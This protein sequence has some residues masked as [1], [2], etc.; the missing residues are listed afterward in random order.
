MKI[1]L[2]LLLS[3]LCTTSAYSAEIVI[4]KISGTTA[5]F[6]NMS[7]PNMRGTFSGT[8]DGILNGR[9]NVNRF[10]NFSSAVHDPSTAGKVIEVTENVSCNTLTIPVD[11][12]IVF[13]AGKILTVANGKALTFLGSFSA[14]LYQVFEALGS[15]NGLKE[16]RPEWFGAARDGVTDDTLAIQK[17]AASLAGATGAIL[18]FSPGKYLIFSDTTGTLASFANMNGIAVL[19]YGTTLEV[20]KTKTITASEG[21][22]F[23]FDNCKNILVD[24]FTTDGPAPDV[25]SSTVKGYEFVRCV[26]GCRNI[27]MP[28]NR[29]VNWIAGLIVS[30]ALGD[31]D[32]MRSQN[33]HIGTLDI[34][35][36]FYGINGQYSGDY[37]VVD[38]LRTDTVHRSFFVYGASNIKANIY[39]KD[40][41]SIDVPISSAGGVVVENIDISYHSGVDST[42]CGNTPK[43]LIGFS[44]SDTA[45]GKMRNV[46]IHLDV[47]YNA[48][49]NTGGAALFIT[50][51][52]NDGNPDASDRGHRMEN[53]IISGEINGS[54]AYSNWAIIVTDTLATWGSGDYFS[55]I[56]LENL[57]IVGVDVRSMIKLVMAG[58]EDQIALTNVVSNQAIAITNA[59]GSYIQAPSTGRVVLN[60]VSCLNRYLFD[61][62]SSSM[63]LDIY[64]GTGTP[65]TIPVGW[66]GKIIGMLGVGGDTVYNLPA[67][68]TGLEYTFTRN[69]APVLDIAPDGTDVIQGGTAGQVLRMNAPGN[70]IK[71]ICI[72]DGTW[73]IASVYGVYSFL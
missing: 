14:G 6:N 44:T 9:V 36:C 28:Q 13:N 38:L 19:G 34:V 37:M 5:I 11:R 33:I 72:V 50:K 1:K 30:K 66:S 54:P 40:H 69:D 18:R 65:A 26:N 41:K 61:T 60:N 48:T 51:L 24:G 57:K 70:M 22:A 10:A 46:K 31:S 29:V 71:L 16:A 67:A 53:L 64:R 49:G 52:K 12:Q 2:L 32:T 7:S 39:S 56:V 8:A 45:I 47:A 63:P 23:Y 59:A 27:K 73:E 3:L 62:V 42:A 17:T 55:N 25:T 21:Q 35:N 58:L 15:I 68:T 43:V 4:T 20:L